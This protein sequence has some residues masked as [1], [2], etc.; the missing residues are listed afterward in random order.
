MERKGKGWTIAIAA[1]IA[2][3]V[4]VCTFFAEAA[5]GEQAAWNGMA[6]VFEPGVSRKQVLVPAISEV[7]AAHPRE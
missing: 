2:V 6:F 5:F 7:L 4:G 1:A 3:I